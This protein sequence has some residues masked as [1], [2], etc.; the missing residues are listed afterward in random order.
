MKLTFIGDHDK[1]IIPSDIMPIRKLFDKKDWKLHR[2][3]LMINHEVSQFTKTFRDNFTTLFISALGLVAAL[4]WNDAIKEAINTLLPDQKTLVY[5]FYVA[6]VVTVISI[7]ATYFL[8][9]L[10]TEK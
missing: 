5:K 7:T 4:T 1:I 3:S 9:K 6:V 10:K 8:S 2:R